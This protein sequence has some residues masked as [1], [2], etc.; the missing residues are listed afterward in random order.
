MENTSNDFCITLKAERQKRKL[1]QKEVAKMLGIT[2][3]A[4]ARKERNEK[5]RI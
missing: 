1:T 2:A 4:Y 3:S 5:K